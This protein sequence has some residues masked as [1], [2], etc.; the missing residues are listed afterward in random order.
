MRIEQVA[1]LACDLLRQRLGLDLQLADLGRGQRNGV[2]ESRDLGFYRVALDA[3]L[4]H[5]DEPA[6]DHV[7]GPP[8]RCPRRP[9]GR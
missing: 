5:V 6:L 9:R 7:R 1:K 2:V 3:V 4:G 8:Q